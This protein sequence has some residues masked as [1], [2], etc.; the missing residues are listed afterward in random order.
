MN[1]FRNWPRTLFSVFA[2][3]AV[4]VVAAEIVARTVFGLETLDYRRPYQPVFVSGDFYN[5]MPNAELPLVP[6]GPVA[7]GYNEQLFGFHYDPATPPPRSSTSMS[8]FLFTHERS[9]YAGPEVDRISCAEPDAALV[10]VLG[11]SVAQGFSASSKATTWHA[12]LEGML[13]KELKREDV[14]VFNAAMGG[15]ISF[16][17]K[18]AYHLAAASR[19]SGVVLFLN[20]YN[21][22]TLPANSGVRP[23]DP[24]QLGLR[25]SQL[26]TDGFFWW[27]ARHSA[28]VRTVVLGEF[29]RHVMA[30]R[31]ALEQNDALFREH[32]EAIT[33]IYI[34]NMNEVLSICEARRQTCLVAVQPSRAVTAANIGAQY[35]DVLSTKQMRQLYDSL[36]AKV[37][38]SP[39]RSKFIDI[40]RIFDDAEKIQYYTDSVHLD[41]RGQ[42]V[43]ADTLLP[44]M[45]E[46]VRDGTTVKAPSNRCEK[47]RRTVSASA[48]S[49]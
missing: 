22:L 47:L 44:R 11:G 21:D 30:Y 16:Q 6:G 37:T 39:H 41:D 15:F 31:R 29:N 4:L 49:G 10:Y 2:V 8:D 17:E 40:T 25:Y 35:D 38:A 32:A 42:K 27:L 28:I 26:F 19:D 48:T 20:G 9:R 34:E 5:P 1:S 12:Q 14:Y 23:G 36:M 18:L 3:V 43:I 33:D 7:Q 45:V 13:R 24:F 46:A